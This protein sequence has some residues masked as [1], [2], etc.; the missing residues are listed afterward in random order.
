[1]PNFENLKNTDIEIYNAI[2]KELKRQQNKIELIASEN[3]VSRSVMEANRKLFNKQ[4][5]RRISKRK[6]LWW[7]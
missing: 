4:V 3:F 1:M 7:M 6:V 2:N 5:C